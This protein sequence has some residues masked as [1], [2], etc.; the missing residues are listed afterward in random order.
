MESEFWHGKWARGETGFHQA[1]AN[2]LL[3]A[4]FEALALGK[5]AHVFVPLCG[6]T[7]DIPWLLSQ[8]YRVSGAELSQ[9]GV[10]AL[11]EAMGVTPEVE[12]L[13]A[14]T[15]YRAEGVDVYVGDVFDVT[16]EVLGKVDAIYD[17]AALVA[18]PEEMR[19]RY[20]AHL[21]QIT[22]N[23]PQFLITFDY[24]QS[25]MDGP[26]FS[27]SSDEVASHYGAH[28]DVGKIASVPVEGGLKGRCPSMEEAWLLRV[29]S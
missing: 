16:A 29:S 10:E 18:L 11:F 13:G 2:P 28:Y 6:M 5:G 9:A 20:T 25:V 12:Q 23:A 8:G 7:L 21:R 4:H 14:L 15:R 1:E 26:P 17:R 27:I 3:A 19:R 24:D 22:E